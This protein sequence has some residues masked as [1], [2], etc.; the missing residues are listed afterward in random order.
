MTSRI[1]YKTSFHDDGLMDNDLKI[2]ISK[3]E[4]D[5]FSTRCRICSKARSTTSQGIGVLESHVKIVKHQSCFPEKQSKLNYHKTYE[6]PNRSPLQ[7]NSAEKQPTIFNFNNQQQMAQAEIMSTIDVVL[8]NYCF[9]S[10]LNKSAL[11]PVIF[12]NSSNTKAFICGETIYSYIICFG[13]APYMKNILDDMI[14]ESFNKSYKNAQMDLYICLWDKK[15]CF[16]V[17]RYCNSEFIRI[18]CFHD[19]C[20]KF[21]S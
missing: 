21:I 3:I 5:G 9:N 15:K 1:K 10:S 18:A 4:N 19:L 14:D 17:T 2:W 8:R 16:D 13:V 11:F 6:K 12:P 7:S 20:E